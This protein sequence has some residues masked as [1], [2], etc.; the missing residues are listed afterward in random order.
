MK[1][2]TKVSKEDKLDILGIIEASPIK[3][4][5][6]INLLG[7]SPVRYY[8][9]Q[10]K[11]YLDNCLD[12]QRG[13]HERKRVRLTDSYRKQIVAAR[14][15]GI[16]GK[17]VIGPETIMGRLEDEGIFLSHET[18]RKVLHQEGLIEPRPK[19][20]RHEWKRF[21]APN[22]NAMWQTDIL[23]AFV[24]GFGY[25]YVFTILDDYSRKIMYWEIFP[26]ATGREAKEV[27]EKAMEVNGVKPE[28]LLTDRGTQ[29]YSGEGKRLG[30]LEAFLEEQEIKHILARVKHPQTLGKIERYHR[31]MRQL[32]L[33]L[34]DFT[35]PHELRRAIRIFVDEYNYRRKH[36]GIGRV[37][38]H[39]KYIGEDKEIIKKRDELRRSIIEQRRKNAFSEDSIQKEVACQEMITLLKKVYTREVVLV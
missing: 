38:P 17:Y 15:E 7:M 27:V 12:D 29:F 35:D 36:K 30:K 11:Y 33:N 10:L 22:P 13:R 4:S 8:R 3:K 9:W 1:G 14:Q 31:T 32:C 21:E 6:A 16:Y 23:Y 24:L 2:Y 37:T 19:V 25:I 28:S 20:L 34:K 39:Q 18:I 5:K 26:F